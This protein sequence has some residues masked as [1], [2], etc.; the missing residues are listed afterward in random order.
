MVELYLHYTICLHGIALDFI[1]YKDNFTS[2]IQTWRRRKH[3]PS[4]CQ[5]SL[6]RLYC[7]TAQIRIYMLGVLEVWYLFI[8]IILSGGETE[9]TWYCCHYWPIVPAP[10]D[11]WWWAIGGLKIGRGKQSTRRAEGA[12]KHADFCGSGVPFASFSLAE[13]YISVSCL[14]IVTLNS[15][16]KSS[17]QIRFSD[18]VSHRI[19]TDNSGQNHSM[20]KT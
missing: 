7:I 18:R 8:I 14:F 20:N 10:D 16:T 1:R 4:K 5:Y 19:Y 17:V 2:T 11:R 12:M 3:V 6:T 13:A 9:S 15:I